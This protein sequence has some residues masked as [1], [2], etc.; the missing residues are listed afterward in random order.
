VP[1]ACSV[2]ARR[3]IQPALP[4][5]QLRDLPLQRPRRRVIFNGYG[6]SLIDCNWRQTTIGIGL[7]LN[8]LL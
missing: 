4:Q 1:L 3:R 5:S 6:E 7:S 8:D 2:D